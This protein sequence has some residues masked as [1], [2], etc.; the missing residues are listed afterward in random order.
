MVEKLLENGVC[1]RSRTFSPGASVLRVHK[2]RGSRL[3]VQDLW[4]QARG[5]RL[6]QGSRLKARGSRLVVQGSWLKARGSSLVVVTSWHPL[7]SLVNGSRLMD[8]GSSPALLIVTPPRLLSTQGSW[9]KAPHRHASLLR[10]QGFSLL[11]RAFLWRLQCCAVGIALCM[12]NSTSPPA[13]KG[14]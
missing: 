1:T 4:L 6:V 11:G 5:S 14:A 2:A 7:P 12:Q 3:V 10:L 8:Q 9:I 13:L